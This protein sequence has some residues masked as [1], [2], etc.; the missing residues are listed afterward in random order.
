[1][2]NPESKPTPRHWVGNPN[3][4]VPCDAM[5]ED[6]GCSLCQALGLSQ[7]TRPTPEQI[8][9]LADA[10]WQLLDDMQDG[11]C[12]SPAARARARVAYEPFAPTDDP[13][14]MDDI[15]PL[16]EAEALLKGISR[17]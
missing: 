15:M 4:E 1:M 6:G 14:A 12:V 3:Y 8:Q 11:T 17:A 7:A 13:G 9:A 16:A 5:G 10:M 2:S